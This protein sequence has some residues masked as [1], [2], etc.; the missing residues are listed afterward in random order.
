M[1]DH[2]RTLG[3]H[4]KAEAEVIKGAYKILAKKYHPDINSSADAAEKMREINEANEVLSDPVRRADYEQDYDLHFGTDLS[5]DPPL[6]KVRPKTLNFG[7]LKVGETAEK[8]FIVKNL[9]GPLKGQLNIDESQCRDWATVSARPL[10]D[11]SVFPLEVTVEVDTTDLSPGKSH[12]A[13]ILLQYLD[14]EIAVSLRVVVLS[15][16]RRRS[17]KTRPTPRTYDPDPF[18]DVGDALRGFGFVIA[19][20]VISA[21]FFFSP[22]IGWGGAQIEATHHAEI[23]QRTEVFEDIVLRLGEIIDLE[24]REVED[25]RFEEEG[26]YATYYVTVENQSDNSH[27]ILLVY[28]LRGQFGDLTDPV[29]KTLLVPP[30][31]RVSF[32]VTHPIG[33]TW[34]PSGG[35]SW[36][37]PGDYFFAKLERVDGVARE[38]TSWPYRWW[39]FELK[40]VGISFNYEDYHYPGE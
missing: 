19:V 17:S 15:S 39:D 9:G 21:W 6:L 28:K 7:E 26:L 8:R 29:Y 37:V 2:Y 3:V 30:R 5:A 1:K 14:E 35:R 25:Q 34:V 40:V 16:K 10:L 31:S 24:K 12:R 27:E 18:M 32:E 38:D 33:F 22:V 4:P 20:A 13:R 23:A 36:Y 11:D